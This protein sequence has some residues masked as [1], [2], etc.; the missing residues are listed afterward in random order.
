M[1]L[2]VALASLV[3]CS[4]SNPDDAPAPAPAPTERGPTSTPNGS[5][6]GTTTPREPRPARYQPYPSEID[7]A[8]KRAAA[9]AIEALPDV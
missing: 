9:R 6:T 2:I 3:G 8:A 1:L 7:S 5:P 4:S